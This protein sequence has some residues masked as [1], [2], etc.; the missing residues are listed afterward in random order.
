[1]KKRIFAGALA[2]ALALSLPVAALANTCVNVKRPADKDAPFTVKGQWVNVG[3][4]WLF[5]SPGTN[6]EEEF[7]VPGVHAPGENGNYTNGRSGSLL[8]VSAHCDTSKTTGSDAH[9]AIQ[10][11]CE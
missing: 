5:V 11:G 3:D 6:V 4:A 8:G 10:T 2:V 7:G 1:M 9:R